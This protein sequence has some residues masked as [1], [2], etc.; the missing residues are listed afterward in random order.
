MVTLNKFLR[1]LLL[2]LTAFVDVNPEE[3]ELKSPVA[4][5][6]ND[7][8]PGSSKEINSNVEVSISSCSQHDVA[9]FSNNLQI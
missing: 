1:E 2:L 3:T 4:S 7:T 8:E 5:S 6:L 9:I